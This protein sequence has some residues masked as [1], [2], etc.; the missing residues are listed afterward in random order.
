MVF[1]G[2]VIHGR[3]VGFTVMV[4]FGIMFVIMLKRIPV[5]VLAC[6]FGS[7]FSLGTVDQGKVDIGRQISGIFAPP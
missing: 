2:L 6:Q 4:S 7:G 1:I 5:K 3:F